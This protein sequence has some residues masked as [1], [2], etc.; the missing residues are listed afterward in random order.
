MDDTIPIFVDTSYVQARVNTRNQWHSAA[1]RYG[2][3]LATERR[4]LVTTEFVPI[5][6]GDA[7]A[8]VGVRLQA[9][10]MV[11][12]LR[13]STLI[14]TVPASAALF[15]AAFVLYRNRADKGWGLTN[16]ISVVVME[17]RG[18]TAALTADAHLRQAGFRALLL[19]EPPS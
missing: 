4:R 8:A 15:D 9:A 14:E 11:D 7:L 3:R 6:F 12:V 2:A 13:G 17:E 5:E 1:V 10:A 16:C 18:L 19:D